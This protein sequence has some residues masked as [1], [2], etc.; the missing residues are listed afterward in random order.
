MCVDGHNK[1]IV[2]SGA[3][4]GLQLFVCKLWVVPTLGEREN[5]SCHGELDHITTILVSLTYGFVSII[6]AVDDT[7]LWTGIT[8]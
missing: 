1:I 3:D 4:H 8:S 2:F 7:L 5:A 6:G